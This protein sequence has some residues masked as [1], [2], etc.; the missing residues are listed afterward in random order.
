MSGLREGLDCPFSG[1]GEDLVNVKF[2]RGTRDDVIT[3]TEML[4]QSSLA[5][6]QVKVKA[7]D[8]SR[9]APVSKHE[10]INIRE[11]A[12]SL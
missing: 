4:E 5:G 8:V 12:A 10:K 11:F 9:N 6:T 1:H 2:F 7:A 3:A